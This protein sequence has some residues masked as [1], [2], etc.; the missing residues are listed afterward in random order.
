MISLLDLGRQLSSDRAP[1]CMLSRQKALLGASLRARRL[2]SSARE[3]CTLVASVAP[4]CLIMVLISACKSCR[5]SSL[6]FALSILS[7]IPGIWVGDATWQNPATAHSFRGVNFGTLSFEG[8]D[9][10]ALVLARVAT[11]LAMVVTAAASPSLVPAAAVAL[12]FFGRPGVA[13][14]CVAGGPIVPSSRACIQRLV[15]THPA[16]CSAKRAAIETASM[17]DPVVSHAATSRKF[18]WVLNC[19]MASLFFLMNLRS[20][21]RS[22]NGVWARCNAC[23]ASAGKAGKI[24]GASRSSLS[25]AAMALC[26]SHSLP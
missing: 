16:P 22:W 5:A 21:A 3:I 19:A 11:H 13:A 10:L 15:A 20:H 8:V 9:V 12:F 14:S 1:S 2:S 18:R 24:S 4:N 25:P 7:H 17:L 23:F 6:E 26:P